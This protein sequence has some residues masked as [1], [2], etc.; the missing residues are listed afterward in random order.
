MAVQDSNTTANTYV[1]FGTGFTD[2]KYGQTFTANSIYTLNAV[3]FKLALISAS[4]DPGV[5][6]VDLYATD[7]SGLPTGSSLSSGSFNGSE[8]AT[9]SGSASVESSY[10]SVKVPMTAYSLAASTK[11]AIVLDRTTD[12]FGYGFYVYVGNTNPYNGGTGITYTTAWASQSS[13]DCWFKTYDTVT[14]KDVSGSADLSFV[15]TGT[16]YGAGG[17]VFDPP[18]SGVTQRRLV[19]IAKSAFWYEV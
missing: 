15:T 13:I 6:S 7:G 10:Q 18:E 14:Y 12:S 9:L 5:I 16:A 11:Y 8:V 1:Y 19:A 2:E 4:R 17:Y 3:E